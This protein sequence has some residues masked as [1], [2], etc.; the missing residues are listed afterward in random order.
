MNHSDALKYPKIY[1]T[2]SSSLHG[3]KYVKMYF[4]QYMDRLF[5]PLLGVANLIHIDLFIRAAKIISF[6]FHPIKAH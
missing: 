4:L 1:S 2:S 5:L 3:T 6:F